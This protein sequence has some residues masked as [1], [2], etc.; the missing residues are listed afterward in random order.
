MDKVIAFILWLV[1]WLKLNAAS[2]IGILQSI[3]KALKEL[4]TAVV[5]LIALFMPAFIS[6]EIVSRVR[7]FFNWIDMGLE[8]VKVNLLPK[9]I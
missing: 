2:L 5:N 9:L 4:G 8:W 6:A 3:V 1:T 7:S